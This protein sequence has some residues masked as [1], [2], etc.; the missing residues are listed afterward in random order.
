MNK[1]EL[2]IWA[3]NIRKT[4]NLPIISNDICKNIRELDLYKKSKHVMIFY[5]LQ[6]EVN[7]LPL[8]EDNKCFYLPC[9]KGDKLLTCPYQKGDEL[10][11]SDLKIMEPKTRAIKPDILDIVFTPALCVDKNFYRLGYGGGFYD[12]FFKNGKLKMKNGKLKPKSICV[13]PEELIIKQLPIEDY[14]I[15]CDGIITQKKASF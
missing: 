8:L 9:V 4:L 11:C 3:K 13:I 1:S 2:R 6:N 12:R 14:D 10:I 15:C 5:P 7:L